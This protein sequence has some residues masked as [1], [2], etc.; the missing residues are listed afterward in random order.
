[1]LCFVGKTQDFSPVCHYPVNHSCNSNISAAQKW[2]FC[3]HKTTPC[4]LTVINPFSAEGNTGK[5]LTL[6]NDALYLTT[7]RSDFPHS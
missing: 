7:V 5:Y 2:T 1:M 3:D 4:A 6:V